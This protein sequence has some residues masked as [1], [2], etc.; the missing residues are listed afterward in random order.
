[1]KR[2]SL[3]LS[4][5]ITLIMLL[6]CCI[7]LRSNAADVAHFTM[8]NVSGEV[9]QTVKVELKAQTEL[10]LEDTSIKISFD[11]KKLS[12]SNDKITVGDA[13]T[14][15]FYDYNV[16]DSGEI[17]F[18]V[19]SSDE[20]TVP[21]GTT[22]LTMNFKILDGA[23]GANNLELYAD[24]SSSTGIFEDSAKSTIT[25][26]QP[27]TGLKLNKTQGTL[28]VG[29][30]ETLVATVEPTTATDKTVTWS[31]SDSKVATVSNGKVVA[32]APGT[33]TITA[34]AGSKTATYTVTV[35]APLT[36]IALNKTELNLL[37]G[38]SETLK[39]SYVPANTTDSKNV[40]W[41]TSDNSI[42]TVENGV[43]RGVKAGKTTITAK[44]GNYTKTCEVTVTEIPLE[45]IAINQKDV[46]LNINETTRLE[47]IFNPQNMTD[48]IG[49]AEWKSSDESVVS[50]KDGE[51]KGLKA[52]TATITVT[53]NGKTASVEVTVTEKTE[54][55]I[56]DENNGN[57][58]ENTNNSENTNT[59]SN[60]KGEE[61][62]ENVEEKPSV[63]PK[64][65]D[66]AI[67]VFVILLIASTTG[68][69]LVI[70]KNKKA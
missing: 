58:G 64:T 60:T 31:S 42:A 37:K 5:I 32:V 29:Q 26:I 17:R 14:K 43:V 22:I 1:M 45:S 6:V 56:K 13:F 48:N 2:K 39:V 55:E 50:V 21:A 52:G 19:A 65:G 35:K 28:N 15:Y 54:E 44:V 10:K 27:V 16:T 7:S 36:G 51:I 61:N 40:V 11:N 69:V 46:E 41:T 70:R 47:V 20:F 53:I 59:E 67:G 30:E 66:I 8:N 9:G 23:V 33:A 62:K 3:K 25:G 68:I 4:L 12:I 34:K 49:K 38:Q 63:L 57:N 24:S 18:G